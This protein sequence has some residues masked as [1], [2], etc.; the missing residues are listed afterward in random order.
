[1]D[2]KHMKSMGPAYNSEDTE[3]HE[4]KKELEPITAHAAEALAACCWDQ[5]SSPDSGSYWRSYNT[6]HKLQQKTTAAEWAKP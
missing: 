1:M 5:A 3:L 4:K 6:H 2:S